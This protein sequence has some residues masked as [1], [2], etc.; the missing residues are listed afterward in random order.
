MKEEENNTATQQ[1]NTAF[2]AP[3]GG[4]PDVDSLAGLDLRIETLARRISQEAVT[5]SW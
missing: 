4:F 5:K 1:L 2:A 3:L